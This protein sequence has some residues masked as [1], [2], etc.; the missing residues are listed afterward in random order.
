MNVL[1]LRTVSFALQLA[2]SLVYLTAQ[3]AAD[4]P[5]NASA[6]LSAQPTAHVQ[7]RLQSLPARVVLVK[8]MTGPYTQHGEGFRAVIDYAAKN[9]KDVRNAIGFYPQDPD[10]VGMDKVEWSVGVILG[11]SS[12]DDDKAAP[13]A[14][15]QIITLAPT[16]AAVVESTL[17]HSA[18]D[19]LALLAWLP[20][21]GYT[22]SGPTQ[23]EYLDFTGRPESRVRIAIPVK[24]RVRPM[25]DLAIAELQPA[26]RTSTQNPPPQVGNRAG[27]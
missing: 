6:A 12:G 19:G 7:V 3:A 21:S 17:Q 4:P 11:E 23:S 24:K 8:Q 5:V 26:P 9:H 20:H 25:P 18:R 13:V 27:P 1:Q 10:A 2:C 16:E 14:P 15:L 22:Q